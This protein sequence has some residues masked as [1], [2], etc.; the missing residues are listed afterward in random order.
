MDS[1]FPKGFEAYRKVK[2]LVHAPA[3]NSR[4]MRLTLDKQ[5]FLT[6]NRMTFNVSQA[7]SA[8]PTGW[9]SRG[10]I[11][12]LQV[13]LKGGNLFDFDGQETVNMCRLL[14]GASMENVVLGLNASAMFSLDLHYLNVN[15]LHDLMTALHTD[16]FTTFD[17]VVTFTTTLGFVGGVDPVLPALPNQQIAF[18]LDA[19]YID[20]YDKD[21]SVGTLLPKK[22]SVRR[23]GF[24][25]GKETYDLEL[26]GL[27]RF[28]MF[29]TLT[30]NADGS[31]TPN[32]SILQKITIKVGD[33]IKREYDAFELKS[34]THEQFSG[35]NQPGVY[36]VSFGDDEA[37]WLNLKGATKATVE[38]EPQV[39][40]PA[41][42]LCRVLQDQSVSVA[43]L[44]G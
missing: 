29:S 12:S 15:A 26:N 33:S 21:P 35:F 38:F 42:W 41:K 43:S 34:D 13:V 10:V 44:N 36:V 5:H 19:K 37:G 30:L 16:K 18:D 3:T 9:S 23:T 22:V 39:G 2:T 6:E 28:I 1:V 27:N 40:A 7:F 32:D 17:L 20:A 25:A 14:G 11:E 24:G 4:Q 31:T 8:A